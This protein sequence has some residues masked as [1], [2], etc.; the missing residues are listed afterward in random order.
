MKIVEVAYNIQSS[1]DDKHKLVVDYHVTNK[2]DF[3]ALAPLA[4]DSK[5]AFSLAVNE[6]L[7]VL[8]DKGYYNG[9]QMHQCHENNIDTLVSPKRGN[10]PDK[11]EHVR[12]DKF[13][14]D[15]S[16]DQYICPQGKPLKPQGRFKRKNNKGEI[17]NYFDR[18]VASYSDCLAC[19]FLE[20][21]VNASSVKNKRGKYIDRSEYDGALERNNEQVAMRKNEYRKRQAIVE[22][23]FGTIKRQWGFTH[24]LMKGLDKVDTEFSL[25]FLAYNF[26][27]VM[28]IMGKKKMKKAL[29]SLII[30][31][32]AMTTVIKHQTMTLLTLN[33]R[34]INYHLLNKSFVNGG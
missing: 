17:V 30:S 24:T 32:L 16:L 19:P 15:K 23:P 34:E 14:Y 9:K 8:A 29:K 13:N 25:I 11:A 22:H 12:K 27:R 3:N 2:T 5:E 33:K 20:D 4:M 28:S 21:C 7:T 26:K 1:V 10:N 31:I 6:Q 18:Y